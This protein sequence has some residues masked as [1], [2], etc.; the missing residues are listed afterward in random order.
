MKDHDLTVGSICYVRLL[1]LCGYHE[2]KIVRVTTVMDKRGMFKRYRAVSNKPMNHPYVVDFT[3][4][5][6]GKWVFRSDET[7]Q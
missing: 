1:G 4:S 7:R 2:A 5:S 6:I 3:E